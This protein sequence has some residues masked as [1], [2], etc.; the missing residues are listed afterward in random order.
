M[1][2]IENYSTCPQSFM[3]G[4]KILQSKAQILAYLINCIVFP[5][6]NEPFSVASYCS[7]QNLN[8]TSNK[9]VEL[10]EFLNRMGIYFPCYDRVPDNTN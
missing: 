5:L 2:H 4:K 9:P 6:A 8:K 1:F 7:Y 10:G 3:Q